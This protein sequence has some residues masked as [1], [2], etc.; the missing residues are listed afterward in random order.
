MEELLKVCSSPL[1]DGLVGITYQE[2]IAM[3][4]AESL[5]NLPIVGVAVLNLV[6]KYVV[7]LL[8][9]LLPYIREVLKDMN[10][11]CNQVLKVE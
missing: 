7:H 3:T 5:I 6:D 10:R 11:E 4:S 9:P 8:L 2:E 1:I